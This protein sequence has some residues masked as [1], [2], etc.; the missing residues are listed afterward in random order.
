M[1]EPVNKFSLNKRYLVLVLV[2]AVGLYVLVPQFGDFKSSLHLLRHPDV[3][4]LLTAVALTA[5]TYLAAAATYCLLAF[6]PLSYFRT[7]L[8]QFAAMFIN[9]LLPG[10]LGALG[11]NYLY[12][13]HSKHTSAQAASVVAVNN[14]LGIMGHALLLLVSILLFSSPNLP[15]ALHGR[16]GGA[17]VL[18][19][20][21]GALIVA[22]AGFVFGKQKFI[23]AINEF[24]AQLWTYR[25]RPGRLLAALASSALLTLFNVLAL[26][27]CALALGVHLPFVTILL[28]FSLGVGAG[29]AT[30]TPGGLGGFEAGLAA[31]FIGYGVG[32]SSALAVALLYRLVSYWLALAAGALAFFI[33]QRRGYI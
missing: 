25:H 21:A 8:V 23:E 12:L 17:T 7:L 13:K 19:V 28:I 33:T 1:D 5:L 26:S 2:L 15:T 24:G 14:V 27:C 4:W 3:G 9:R 29:T 20:A 22:I 10:G 18:Y 11:A 6:K 31:G 32:G 30:P 16:F